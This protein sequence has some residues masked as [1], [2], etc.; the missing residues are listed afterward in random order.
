MLTSSAFFG[1]VQGERQVRLRQRAD[2]VLSGRPGRAA[3]LD[4]RRRLAVGDG[5]Q[6]ARGIQGRRQ[7]LLLPL[8][9]R[10]PGAHPPAVGLP[11]DHQGGL[12]EEQGRRASTRTRPISRRRCSSSPTRSR[13]RTRAGL[14]LGN[15]VQLRDVWAEE[16]ESAL[17]G[18][19]SAKEALDAAVSRGNADA[20]PVRA[21]G[22]AV[23]AC[24]SGA[25]RRAEPGTHGQAPMGSGFSL[26][27]PRKDSEWPWKSARS[28]RHGF[29]P[30]RCSCRSSRSRSCSSTGRRARPCWQS[31]LLEDAFGLSREFVGF[32]NYR[33]LFAQ[34]EYYAAMAT[35]LVFSSLV[36]ALSLSC[37]LLLATQADKN[38]RAAPGL[39]DA[40]DLALCGRARRRRRAVAVHLPPVARHPGAADASCRRRLEPAAQ[41]PP[42]HDARRPLGDLEADQLQ[43]P[44]LPRRAAGDPDGA[45]SRRRRSTGRGRSG[46][47][48]PSSSRCCRR[49]PSSSSS[50]TSST[51][52]S[53]PSASSTP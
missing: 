25:A 20:A 16:I 42:R 35:T 12:P 4:H 17:A 3:E 40:A 31:F 53:T 47:S 30:T 5:R 9:H 52:S 13:P 19:K 39:Q 43:L 2:A 44:V 49:R 36:A 7:V 14:R 37:A 29:C 28:S 23:N 48:G 38:L 18:K 27:E 45:S 6:E 10:P 32:E 15:M 41:R 46:A 8:G 24:H 22:G 21:D 11:A 51:S 50:S 34:P 1:N 26:R 33:A